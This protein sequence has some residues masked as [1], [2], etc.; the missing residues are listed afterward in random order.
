MAS[1]ESDRKE[2]PCEFP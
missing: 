1:I 2:V